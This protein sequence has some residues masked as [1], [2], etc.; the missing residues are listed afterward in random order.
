MFQEKKQKR[1]RWTE[2]SSSLDEN[3][4]LIPE[5]QSDILF[6][7]NSEFL[8]E[9]LAEEKSPEPVASIPPQPVKT[10]RRR[11]PWSLLASQ[12]GLLSSPI[13]LNAAAAETVPQ[14]SVETAE[15]VIQKE[16]PKME[17]APVPVESDSIAAGKTVNLSD[18]ELP[19]VLWAPRKVSLIPP[20]LTDTVSAAEIKSPVKSS[21]PA[22]HSNDTPFESPQE[23]EIPM[24]AFSSGVGRQKRDR[25]RSQDRF[26]TPNESR[27]DSRKSLEP[28]PAEHSFDRRNRDTNRRGGM[29]RHEPPKLTAEEEVASFAE[30]FSR[31]EIS[32]PS[33]RRGRN[34]PRKD[35]FRDE[36]PSEDFFGRNIA[37]PRAEEKPSRGRHPRHQEELRQ[38]DLPASRSG[39]RKE[40]SAPLPDFSQIHKKIPSWDDA[41]GAII[42]ANMSRQPN[43]VSQRKSN[44]RGRRR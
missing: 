1:D 39:G 31:T 32:E 37:E 35:R 12:L 23:P 19:P 11:D 8:P 40:E 15:P 4:E 10:A 30:D 34:F 44:Y 13:D 14:D 7:E 41:I 9:G 2:L 43:R 21:K 18:S 5:Q 28:F 26:D 17:S 20:S 22:A 24:S 42:D 6:E 27:H 38:N 3:G 16:V 29:E 33:A 25:P 36:K